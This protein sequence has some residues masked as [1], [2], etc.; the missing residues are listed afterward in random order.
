MIARAFER[1]LAVRMNERTL[2]WSLPR[3]GEHTLAWPLLFQRYGWVLSWLGVVAISLATRPLLPIDETRYVS[4]AWEMWQRGD[5]LVPYLN[6][7]PYSHKP[8]LLFWLIESG[9]WMFG[10]QSWWPRLVPALFALANLVGVRRLA[11]RLWP[12]DDR[13]VDLSAWV[14]AGC[15]GFAVYSSALLFDM[16]VVTGVLVALAGLLAVRDGFFARGW[17]LVAAGVALGLYAKGPVALVFVLPPILLLRWWAAPPRPRWAWP[18]AILAVVAGVGAI[19]AWALPAA[20]AG[21]VAYGQAI[22]WGQTADRVVTAA[23]HPEPWYWYLGVLPAMLMPYTLWPELWRRLRRLSLADPAVR[24]CLAASLPSL[25]VMSAISAKQPHY[26]LA[27]VPPLALLA[28]RVAPPRAPRTALLV[29]AAV[30][31]LHLVAMPLLAPEVDLR[32]TARQLA[33]AQERGEPIAHRGYYHG[34]YHFLGRLSQPFE[35]L[36]SD[37]EARA[38]LAAHPRGL[39]VAYYDAAPPS[40]LGAPEFEQPFRGRR[41]GIF[42]P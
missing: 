20:R 28:A 13:A 17:A 41:V 36:L 21:G 11:R 26:L 38:W 6:G 4:V 25:V 31:F 3:R 18:S 19:L 22:L 12:D 23:A 40:W 7:L 24:F 27:L 5:Q 16:L 42:R 33:V 29:P 8:P 15:L 2:P 1:E 37:G 34:Q 39:L 35:V 32:P 30:C 9:W 14:L 10:V